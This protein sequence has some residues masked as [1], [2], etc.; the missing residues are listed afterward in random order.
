MHKAT[1]MRPAKIFTPFRCRLPVVFMPCIL[2][3]N[4][5]FDRNVRGHEHA[6]RALEDVDFYRVKPKRR[7]ETVRLQCCS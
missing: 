6:R 2:S 1:S 4:F 3:V 7:A 5:L